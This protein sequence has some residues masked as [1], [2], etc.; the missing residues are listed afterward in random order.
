MNVHLKQKRIAHGDADDRH[1]IRRAQDHFPAGHVETEQ[2]TQRDDQITGVP[3]H[4]AD[5][6]AQQQALNRHH[7]EPLFEQEISHPNRQHGAKAVTN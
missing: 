2:T 4:H 3:A 1:R 6:E 5:A 7:T